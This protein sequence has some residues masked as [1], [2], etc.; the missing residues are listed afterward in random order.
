MNLIRRKVNKLTTTVCLLV[1]CSS[2][3]SACGGSGGGSDGSDS[4][5]GIG[6]TGVVFGKITGFGSVHVNG[7][8]FDI[9][10]SLFD[11]DGDTGADQGDLALGMVITLKV[12]T[13]NG[14]YTGK[15]LEVVY[16]DEIQGPVMSISTPGPGDTQ[17]TFD[18]FG[19]TITIDETSTVFEGT[20]FLGL[21][22]NDVVEISG[23]RTSDNEINATYVEWKETL[24]NGSEVELRGTVSG[25]MPPTMQFMLDGILINFDIDTTI[26]V[27][28]DVLENGQFVEV[29][30]K[31]QGPAVDADEIEFEEEGF[32]DDVDNID[33]QGIIS[34]FNSISD[35]EI[36]GQA[37]DVS[38]VSTANMSPANAASLLGVG[39]EIEVEG[40]IVNGVLIADELELRE[41]ET[42]LK[43]FV[44]FV[45]PDNI[46]FE[47]NY[48]G[49]TGSI[50]INT[51]S[52]TLFKDEGPLELP[53]FSVADMN[54]GDFVIVEGIE[55]ADE[56]TAET[57]KRKN[58]MDPDDSE[59][60]GQVDTF[61]VDTSI[62]V[63]GI[64]YKV[65]GGTDYE[66]AT[67]TVLSTI[68][69]NQLR[70]G[71]IV[72]IKDEVT[73]DGFAEE[74]ELD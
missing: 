21:D 24:A 44:S 1:I 68:F 56:V 49:L 67:G 42:K 71:D 45:Y 63:L 28:N 18:V 69:F 5:A 27:P 43:S 54:V 38:Q 37:I 40:D 61:V 29:K 64:T 53:N 33:L 62:T 55:S 57:V 12:E 73:A 59:L 14:V 60:E 20:T 41:G 17:R 66:D 52:Q 13:E 31:Y 10:T 65:N 30:G 22:N 32:G 35:F 48:T 7:D 50:L 15:A 74:V 3:L 51:N 23:F 2:L 26:D 4:I 46:R 9:D 6:G 16:D 47:I 8:I 70:D 11:V 58:S 25:Y 36:D 34:M 19:Q 72:E 39:V